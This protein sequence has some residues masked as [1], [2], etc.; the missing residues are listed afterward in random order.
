MKIAVSSCMAKALALLYSIND[1]LE[2]LRVV[3]SEVSQHL[4]VNLNTILVERTHEL[5]IAQIIEAGSSI[6]TLNP[7]RT[8]VALL[9]TTVAISVGETLFIGIFCYRPDVF[10][11]TKV[12]FGLLQNLGSPGLRGNMIY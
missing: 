7:K 10:A 9:G 4:A 12:T 5:T 3:D 8:E 1:S 11:C 6:D 2:S